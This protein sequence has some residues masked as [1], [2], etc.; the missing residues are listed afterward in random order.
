VDAN[1]ALLGVQKLYYRLRSIDNDKKH[2][3][4]K[5]EEV[6]LDVSE[7]AYT[8]YPNPTKNTLYIR[9]FLEQASLNVELT[10]LSGKT[11][12]TK[13]LRGLD[14]RFF[15]LNMKELPTGIYVLKLINSSGVYHEKVVKQ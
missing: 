3:L 15:K 4:S 13:E 7:A 6:S 1:A 12:L 9:S 2:N 11:V 14:G 10:D 8:V 5:V